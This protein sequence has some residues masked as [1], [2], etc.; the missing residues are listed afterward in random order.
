MDMRHAMD[1]LV[2][3]S[4][5]TPEFRSWFGQS[6]IV[7]DAGAPLMVFHQTSRE[8]AMAI[9]TDGFD[10][11][12]LGARAS[13]DTM[14]DGIFF[15]ANDD[16]IR[17]GGKDAVQMAF[18]L[19]IQNPL[20][21]VNR[22]DLKSFLNKDASYQK[23]SA[24]VDEVDKRLAKSYDKLMDRW[25]AR[26]Q[27]ASDVPGTPKPVTADQF[28]Q[29]SAKLNIQCDRYIKQVATIAR[30]RATKVIKA[31][32]YDGLWMERDVGGGLFGTGYA[33]MAIVAFSR[34]QVRSGKVDRQEQIDR[35]WG[36]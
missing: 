18:F 27:P 26:G 28:D 14:P 25:P 32:G 35:S 15:K 31:A 5:D 36:R 4:V 8:S 30:A 3:G 33:P 17:V 34:D 13:D 7:D 21:V 10:I 29:Y 16:D 20:R 1:L 23:F 6:K 2:E 24:K 12:R 9:E 19:S 22:S 11:E